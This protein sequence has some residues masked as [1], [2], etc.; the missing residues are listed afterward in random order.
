MDITERMKSLALKQDWKAYYAEK[1]AEFERRKQSGGWPSATCA[2]CKTLPPDRC[3]QGL[4][5]GAKDCCL[6]CG[7]D[8]RVA[9]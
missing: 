2:N 3:C 4:T 9:R 6:H 7:H 1:A 5:H 8:E